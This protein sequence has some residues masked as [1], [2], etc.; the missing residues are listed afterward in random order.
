MNVQVIFKQSHKFDFDIFANKCL[1]VVVKSEEFKKISP[2]NIAELNFFMFRR[3]LFPGYSVS[4]F[5]FDLQVIS[6]FD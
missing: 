1:Y 5:Y 3:L 6:I 4:I 2:W